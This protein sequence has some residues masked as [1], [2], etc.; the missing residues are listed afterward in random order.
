MLRCNADENVEKE[1]SYLK[2]LMNKKVDGVILTSAGGDHKTIKEIV[3]RGM[4]VVLI[5]RLVDGLDTD[6]VIIDNV[7]GAYDATSHLISEGYRKIGIITGPLEI[8]IQERFEGYTK[9]L[10]MQG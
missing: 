5:D 8:M 7:S 9:A 1:T 2:V 6:G 10:Q 4:P 3:R